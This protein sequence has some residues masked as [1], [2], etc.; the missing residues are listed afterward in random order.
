M[1]KSPLYRLYLLA[2]LAFLIALCKYAFI[3]SELSPFF[4]I[5]E[6]ISFIIFLAIIFL[7]D[8]FYRIRLLDKQ[9]FQEELNINKERCNDRIAQLETRI[10]NELNADGYVLDADEIDIIASKIVA[11]SKDFKDFSHFSFLFLSQLASFYEVVLGVCYF[12]SKPSGVFSVK[13][14][15]GLGS[16]IEIPDFEISDGINGQVVLDQKPMLIDEIDEDYFHVE[17]CSGSAIPKCIYLLPI[18]KNKE[19]IG[20]IELASFRSINIDQHWEKINNHIVEV[21]F[22]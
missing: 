5:I 9:K 20:L 21:L 10:S 14:T 11:N 2:T 22:L 1:F 17:S 8:K 7:A 12:R 15:F 6:M 4:L 13:G 18:V 3:S 16:E 19:T